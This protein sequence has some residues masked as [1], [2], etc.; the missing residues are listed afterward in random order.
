MELIQKDETNWAQI[1]LENLDEDESYFNFINSIKSE[2]TKANYLFNLNLYMKFC[3]L[4]KMSDLLTISDPQ[5]Q[6]IKYIMSLRVRKMATG[7]I[8]TMV[9]AIYHFYDMNDVILNKKKINMFKGE[10]SRTVI[11]RPYTH[12]EIS[13]ALNCADLRMKVAI[14]LM[15]S[16]GLRIGAIPQLRYRNL[17]R[18]DSIYKITIYEGSNEQYYTFCTPECAYF[19]DSYLEYRTKNGE[20]IDNDSYL[21]RDQFDI[22]DLEQITNKS[23]GIVVG[24]IRV[25]LTTTLLKAGLI[26]IDHINRHKR[27][28]VP[29]AHGFRKFFATSCASSKVDPEIR[30][31]LLGHDIGLALDYVKPS[32]EEMYQEYQKAFDNLT[33]NEENRLRNKVKKLEFERSRLDQLELTIKKLEERYNKET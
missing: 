16:A 18:I 3:N 32:V 25:M 4:T 22:T 15:A 17:E 12:E 28:P 23:K 8:S 14:L 13:R 9:N 5:K 30:E 2:V 27:K 21:I 24:T 29:R 33:I 6:I 19:I 20:K 31:R 7:S 26:T 1:Q 11:D 10:F